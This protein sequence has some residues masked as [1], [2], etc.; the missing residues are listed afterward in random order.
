MNL[1]DALRWA[2]KRIRHLARQG[3]EPHERQV[4][5]LLVS[6]IYRCRDAAAPADAIGEDDLPVHFPIVVDILG[7][8]PCP[9]SAPEAFKTTCWCSDP[10]CTKFYGQERNHG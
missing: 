7:R 5:R 6:E 1:D 8:G 4:L 10:D 3:P 9:E 2:H